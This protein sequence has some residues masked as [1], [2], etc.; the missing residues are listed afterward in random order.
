M[1]SWWYR[2]WASLWS[3]TLH[4]I[5]CMAAYF[6]NA[7]SM[8]SHM[9]FHSVW[10][11]KCLRTRVDLVTLCPHILMKHD[12]LV[13]PHLSITLK[14]IEQ[15]DDFAFRRLNKNTWLDF[16]DTV[17]VTTRNVNPPCIDRSSWNA[18]LPWSCSQ[19]SW[20]S[21]WQ[22]WFRKVLHKETLEWVWTQGSSETITF[23]NFGRQ[24]WVLKTTSNCCKYSLMVDILVWVS[25]VHCVWFL[26]SQS[27]NSKSFRLLEETFDWCKSNMTVARPILSMLTIEIQI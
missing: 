14:P 11:H 9:F 20:W 22:A 4:E 24:I 6:Q 2:M 16:R 18:A 15:I 3:V 5:S 8:S 21:T 17:S 23:Q 27:D 10:F 13:I 26:K 12:T 25:R 7:T 19:S 1:T